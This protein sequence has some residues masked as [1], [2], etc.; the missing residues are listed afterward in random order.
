AIGNSASLTAGTIGTGDGFDTVSQENLNAQFADLEWHFGA[1]QPGESGAVLGA[2]VAALGNSLT[3]TAETGDLYLDTVIQT[4]LGDKS[5][6]GTFG[7]QANI[8]ISTINS[9]AAPATP[10]G[11]DAPTYETFD[12]EMVAAAIGNSATL[13]AGGDILLDQ[14]TQTVEAKQR[15]AIGMGGIYGLGDLSVTAVAIGNSLSIDAG[16]DIAFDKTDGGI[17]QIFKRSLTADVD[18]NHIGVDGA[19]DFTSAAIGNSLSIAAGGDIDLGDGNGIDQSNT[20]W[21]RATV[22]LGEING[23]GDMSLTTVA[24]GN[25]LSMTADGGFGFGDEGAIE[26]TNSR[27]QE[28]AIGLGELNGAGVAELTAAAIGN[29]LSL[30][31]GGA[32]S[33]TGSI[34]Q[35]ND[36]VNEGY[37]VA[38]LD[39]T[40][41]TGS[42]ASFDA[43]AVAIGNSLSLSAG[44]FA[45]TGTLSIVQTNAY[46][47]TVSLNLADA[48]IGAGAVTSAAIGN[49][50]SVTIK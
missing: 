46:D 10:V 4:N 16:G 17:D 45:G 11:V 32:L 41:T 20:L 6:A 9:L 8:S 25:S 40:G 2:T 22:D 26:Q 42:F 33:G 44:S 30:D 3:L 18:V 7:Q 35:T 19:L 29:S 39:L 13:N 15:A 38:S 43:T 31:A 28:V 5:T 21:Q 14:V 24:I 34:T 23:I 47:Q 49:S 50:A 37:Q 36:G 27:Y 1:V 12:A 48:G